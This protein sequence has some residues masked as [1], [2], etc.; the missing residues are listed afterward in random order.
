MFKK[1]GVVSTMSPTQ[2][3]RAATV[4][5]Q[6]YHHRWEYNHRLNRFGSYVETR[7]NGAQQQTVIV[8]TAA[9]GTG[10]DRAYFREYVT[11]VDAANVGFQTGTGETVVECMRGVTTTFRIKIDALP[12]KPDLRDKETYT[13]VLNGFDLYAKRH[14]DKLIAFDLE[15]TEPTLST[16]GTRLRFDILGTLCFDCR[17]AEC[18]L[19]PFGLEVEEVGRRRRPRKRAEEQ[20][21]SPSPPKKRGIKRSATL[22]KAVA[23]LKQ[24]IARFTDLE[25]V[26]AWVLESDENRQR[27][28]LFR[29]LGKQFYLRLLKWRVATPYVLRVPYLIVAGDRDAL[30]VTDT[31]PYHNTYTWDTETE[32]QREDLGIKSVE[33]QGAPPEAYAC[34]LFAFKQLSLSAELDQEFGSDNPI[35]WGRGMHLLEWSVAVRDTRADGDRVTADLDLFY[36][37]WSAAMNEVITLTTWG[38]LRSAGSAT[39]GARLALLQFKEA[40]PPTQRALPGQLYWPGGGLNAGEHPRARVERLLSTINEREEYA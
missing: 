6:G 21:E 22:D 13:V 4:I 2:Q 23:W 15:V 19:W 38:A 20:Q 40:D 27:R 16:D 28:R 30:H 24:Q 10:G 3:R 14:S 37:S 29:L 1:E 5:W 9:S 26:K 39:V 32:I 7:E 18:Q 34:N 25:N 35:Q 12:L 33:V 31:E 36:K 11:P 17:T 8:H